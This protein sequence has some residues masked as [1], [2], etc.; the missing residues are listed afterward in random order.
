MRPAV[1][2]ALEKLGN[3][4]LAFFGPKM[5]TKIRFEKKSD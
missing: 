5:F 3:I 4:R 2:H 1:P